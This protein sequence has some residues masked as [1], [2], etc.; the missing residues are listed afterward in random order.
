VVDFCIRDVLALVKV[1]RILSFFIR[2]ASRSSLK[3]SLSVILFTLGVCNDVSDV[4]NLYELIPGA[5]HWPK[6]YFVTNLHSLG[7]FV[8]GGSTKIDSYFTG[9]EWKDLRM[10]S[11]CAWRRSNESVV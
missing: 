4:S 10:P 11:R 6:L 2:I 9:C 5:S 8:P 3:P 7:R 1:G